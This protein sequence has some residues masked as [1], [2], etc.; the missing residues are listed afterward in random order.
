MMNNVKQSLGLS[1]VLFTYKRDERNTSST[2]SSSSISV[3]RD[4]HECNN[5]DISRDKHYFE[6]T[7]HSASDRWWTPTSMHVRWK[8][9]ADQ[10]FWGEMNLVKSS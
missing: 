5:Q 8:M 3:S 1:N 7:V 6:T 9:E 4:Q 10:N 2:T